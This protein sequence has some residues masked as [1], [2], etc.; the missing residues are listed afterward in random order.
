MK[1]VIAES[2]A[3]N[4]LRIGLVGPL[5]PPFGGMA[6]QTN[7]LANLLRLEG[8]KVVLVQTNPPY[9]NLLL[10]KLKGF[11]ALLRL[12]L[13]VNALWRVTTQVDCLHIMANSGWSWQLFAAPAIWIGWLKSVPVVVNYRGGEAESY[14]KK[15]IKFVSPTLNKCS[16][17]IVPSPFLKNVFKTF[18]F[19]AEVIPNIVD[20]NKFI[21]NARKSVQDIKY[22]IIVITRNLEEIYGIDVAINAIAIVKNKFPDIKVFIAGSGPLEEKL[23]NL[24]ADKGLVSN[25]I[26]TGKLTPDDVYKLYSK[27][28]IMLNPTTVDNMPNSVLEALACG[29]AVVSTNVGGIPYIVQNDQTALLVDINDSEMMATKI[30]QLI[31]DPKLYETLVFNGRNYVEKY[32]WDIVK[33]QWLGLYNRLIV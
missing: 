2:S 17:L 25:V 19:S 10:S 3:G 5:P 11:R 21:F 23:R 31:N 7:Q 22:P 16:A 4:S 8:I 28:D 30:E 32:G 20:L 9:P 12:A 13:Y 33:N 6:N 14:L 18:G 27:S 15:S 26:F 29:L 24:V 1:N